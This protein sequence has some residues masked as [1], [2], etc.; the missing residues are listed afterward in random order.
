MR[1][2]YPSLL[3]KTHSIIQFHL[4]AVVELLFHLILI[5]A[6]YLTFFLHAYNSEKQSA[7]FPSVTRLAFHPV[8]EQ[9]HNHYYALIVI[10]HLFFLLRRANHRSEERRVR[11]ECRARMRRAACSR[12]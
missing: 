6:F 10:G 3:Y 12:K 7:T 5:S 9:I 2:P 8:N 1:P 11:K 4:H